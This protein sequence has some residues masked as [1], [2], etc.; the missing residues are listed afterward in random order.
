MA[1]SN[2]YVTLSEFQEHLMANGGGDFTEEDMFN[3]ERAIEAASRAIDKEM[4]TNFYGASETRHYTAEFDDLLF[5]PDDLISITTLKTDED[6]DGTY[7]VTWTTSDYYLEPRNARVKAND[8]D[9]RPYRQIRIN[10][11]GDYFF[12]TNPYGVQIIGSFGYTTGI[13]SGEPT[14]VP[15]VIRQATM[16]IAHRWWKRKDAIFGIAGTPA[17]GVQVIQARIMKDDDI[18]WL[19]QSV[20]KR[21]FYV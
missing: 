4:D 6:D 14:E 3:M 11:N 18:Q 1:I 17:L 2:G 20:D 5:L 21:G 15:S 16:L 10:Q 13:V 7:E 19:L 12:P 9:N 8:R